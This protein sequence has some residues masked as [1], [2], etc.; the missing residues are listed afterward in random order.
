MKKIFI[1]IAAVICVCG[2]LGAFLFSNSSEIVYTNVSG[3]ELS[4]NGINYYFITHEMSKG[5][6]VE[7]TVAANVKNIA[8]DIYQVDI[9]F[10]QQKNDSYS[11]ENLDLSFHLTDNDTIISQFYDVGSN[12]CKRADISYID[13]FSIDCH[14]DD[15]YIWCSF[16]VRSDSYEHLI[17]PGSIELNYDITGRFPYTINTFEKI[18]PLAGYIDTE[19]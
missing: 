13:G 6:N 16:V 14:S 12:N 5:Q 10:D 4:G 11:I 15:N 3:S 18:S 17:A 19:E 9:F 2:I 7:A 8:D 1:E